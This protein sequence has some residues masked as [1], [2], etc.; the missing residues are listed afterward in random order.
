M[1]YCL[2]KNINV[3]NVWILPIPLI[4]SLAN[5]TQ[6]NENLLPFTNYSGGN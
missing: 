2:D 6:S 4:L 3:Q 1:F 5:L